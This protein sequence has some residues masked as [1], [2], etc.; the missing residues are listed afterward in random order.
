MLRNQQIGGIIP[1]QLLPRDADGAP[2][3]GL[4]ERNAELL[5]SAGGV[6]L[7]VN[8]ATGEYVAASESERIEA[9]VRARRVAG[10]QGL[11][12]SAVG[13]ASLRETI[14]LAHVSQE[15]GADIILIPP[16]HFFRYEQQDLAEFYRQ[17]VAALRVPALLYNLPSFTAHLDSSLCVELIHELP[18]L[19]GIKDSSGQLDILTTLTGPDGPTGV[20][21]VGNDTV[22][23]EAM[24]RQICDGSI[25]GVAGVLPELTIGLW[26]AGVKGATE[27][28]ERISGLL[29][30]L[31]A[32]LDP[33]PI[34]WGIKL[35]SA[36]RGFGTATFALPSSAARQKQSAEFQAWFCEWWPGASDVLG[37]PASGSMSLR[38]S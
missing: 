24:R 14:A 6:G 26:D 31:L 36:V 8:G 9:V 2:A 17:A 33:F 13:A 35:I 30:E 34:P 11:V 15:E 37:I 4:F 28:F 3:W 22:L 25:S 12:V 7:C 1:A 5:M 20:R 23:A 38:N 27:R 32:Q 21:L 18:G 19:A 29:D 16:P 10:N